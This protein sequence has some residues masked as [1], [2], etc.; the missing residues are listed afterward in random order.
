[1]M[2]KSGLAFAAVAA[3]S[4][5]LAHSGDLA[6]ACVAALEADGRDTSGC[7]CLE[8]E[9]EANDLV[10]EFLALGEIADPAERYEAASD[11]AKAAMNKCTR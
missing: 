6:D 11:E 4:I 8:E 7:T 10:D 5:S 1:M 9:V 3:A 2:L